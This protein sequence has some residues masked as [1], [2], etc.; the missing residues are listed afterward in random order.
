MP[1]IVSLSFSLLIPRG[2]KSRV[3]SERFLQDQVKCFYS[4]IVTYFETI[5]AE[6]FHKWSLANAHILLLAIT[7]TDFSSMSVSTASGSQEA[8]N[9]VQ[10]VPE[11]VTLT[12]SLKKI[13]E[14]VTH[15][16][17]WFKQSLR[18]VAML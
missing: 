2:R 6:G 7:T 17:R 9:I 4:S 3:K 14:D 1:F 13:R 15:Y 12:S 16:K 8:K 11:V 5:A 10:T 18:R